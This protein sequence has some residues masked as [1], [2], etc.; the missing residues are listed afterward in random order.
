MRKRCIF[1]LIELLVVIAII[2]ILAAMLMPALGAARK[3]AQAISCRSNQRQLGLAMISYATDYNDWMISR[4]RVGAPAGEWKG[5]RFTAVLGK[6]GTDSTY[7]YCGSQ[8]YLGYIN[9]KYQ[10]NDVMTGLMT[11][12]GRSPVPRLGHPFV[13]NHRL[14]KKA[15]SAPYCDDPWSKAP[16]NYGYF[17][18]SSLKQ[19]SKT[20]SLIEGPMNGDNG[21]ICLPHNMSMNVFF[22][23][24]HSGNVSRQRYSADIKYHVTYGAYLDLGPI[25]NAYP[26]DGSNE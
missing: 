12:P 21:K 9:W 18:Q 10:Q 24:G 4:D 15:N 22:V 25:W 7:D 2:A 13:T 17:K 23:D 26:F 1:T 11:C 8:V 19:G 14:A 5:P 3:K 6:K 20:A 16:G